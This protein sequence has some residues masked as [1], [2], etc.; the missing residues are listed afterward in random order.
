MICLKVNTHNLV[1]RGHR[2]YCIMLEKHSQGNSVMLLMNIVDK[3][4][5]LH[6]KS[7]IFHKFVHI[8]EE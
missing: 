4:H 6:W 7:N 3:L 2:I 1:F 8:D 5:L